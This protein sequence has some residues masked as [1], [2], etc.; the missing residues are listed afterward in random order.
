[1]RCR[2]LVVAEGGGEMNGVAGAAW[3]MMKQDGVIASGY[4]QSPYFHLPKDAAL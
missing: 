1:M 2:A 3:R 4:T